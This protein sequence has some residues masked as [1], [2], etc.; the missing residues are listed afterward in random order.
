MNKELYILMG[1]ID[2]WV[3]EFGCGKLVGGAVMV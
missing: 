3:S 1:R 2:I